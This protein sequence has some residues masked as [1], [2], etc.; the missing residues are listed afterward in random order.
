[1]A[2]HDNDF[3]NTGKLNRLRLASSSIMNGSEA[4]VGEG[5][6]NWLGWPGCG[7]RAVRCTPLF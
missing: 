5:H 4:H 6:T 2:S 3:V 1:M 7:P